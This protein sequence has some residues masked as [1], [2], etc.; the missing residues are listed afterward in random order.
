MIFFT[1]LFDKVPAVQDGKT[2][3]N[4]YGEAGRH[5]RSI[6]EI[7]EYNENSEISDQQR[8]WLHC[9]AGPIRELVKT[10]WGFDDAK[11]HLKV[12][13]GREWFVTY[14]TPDNYHKLK[15]DLYW[16]CEGLMCRKLIHPAIV[17]YADSKRV[18]PFC[19][20]P[21]IRL[22]AVKSIMNVSVKNTTEWFHN[23]WDKFPRIKRPDPNWPRKKKVKKDG[24]KRVK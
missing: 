9:K 8:K 17:E 21:D 14:V 13:H 16:E 22:I 20:K 1:K 7:K 23:I 3:K 10:G 2:W 19:K 12:A 11:L 18:C 6:I 4:I 5:H 24:S 15:G